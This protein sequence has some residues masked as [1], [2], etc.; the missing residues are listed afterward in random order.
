MDKTNDRSSAKTSSKYL[1]SLKQ[2]LKGLWREHTH[3]MGLLPRLLIAEAIV[4][5]IVFA[6]GIFLLR[7]E[8]NYLKDNVRRDRLLLGQAA[9]EDLDASLQQAVIGLKQLAFQYQVAVQGGNPTNAQDA[10]DLLARRSA[11]FTGGVLVLGADGKTAG[12]DSNHQQLA[13][14]DLLQY[15]PGLR[16]Q[17]SSSAL[18]SAFRLPGQVSPVVAIAVPLAG[19][20]STGYAVGVMDTLDA[21]PSQVAYRAARLGGS[22]HA[23]IVD[24]RGIAIFSTEPEYLLIS[25]DHRNSY[26]E[27]FAKG[28]PV[29]A[30]LPQE[31]RG[32]MIPGPHMMSFVPLKTMPWAVS[33]GTSD[34]AAF[35][36]V[37]KLWYGGLVF[38]NILTGLAFAAT[39]VVARRL[40]EP[41]R[42]LSEAAKDVAKGNRDLALEA[43]W[44]GEIGELAGS[45]ETM[46][47]RLQAWGVE[48]E[49]RVRG[50]TLE[51]EERNRELGSL[52]ETLQEKEEQL[53]SLL[54]KV[55]SAQ[56]DERRRVSRELH[57]SIG[58]ALSALSMGLERLEQ[59]RPDQWP[60]LRGEAETLKELASNT[61]ND[62]RRLT[63]ALR[64]AALDDL[65]LVPAIRRYAE[66]YL[67]SARVN[68]EVK[69]EWSRGRM[70]HSLEAIV[71]RV[72]QEAINNIARHSRATHVIVRI[73]H[74]DGTVVVTV[75][76]NGQGFEPNV[77][78]VKGRMGIQGM[79]ERASL[80][81][82]KLTIESHPGRG[83]VVRL[84]IPLKE[85]A[86]AF[87]DK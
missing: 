38:L 16:L 72:V 62:L 52:Y 30:E 51:L 87:S 50:R 6:G 86:E 67:G 58:Q 53:R 70:D 33:I 75:E 12:T 66:L 60:Q 44:G 27:L 13:R 4:F 34:S 42:A 55:L 25:S 45:L 5:V 56:E 3:D 54:E 31:E 24:E 46:R 84:K 36:S 73:Q 61:L 21:Y 10:L 64:P 49:G 9:A 77:V 37:D 68:F 79:Q 40:V 83:T 81:D 23:D 11:I 2:A 18:S 22:G 78:N 65:G 29:V 85:R 1:R 76:D 41:I 47:Q 82:G 15:W 39:I 35:S 57:D 80:V 63:V 20:G 71:Y 28:E 14:I 59:S 74:K 48:L 26:R 8:T 69:E 17:G 19:E 7:L 32:S 43:E